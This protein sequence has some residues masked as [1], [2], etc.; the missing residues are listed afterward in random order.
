MKPNKEITK[1]YHCFKHKCYCK[2]YVDLVIK[3]ANEGK[4]STLEPVDLALI[5]ECNFKERKI[6]WEKDQKD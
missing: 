2:T 4:I 1:K 6:K 3:I 5:E